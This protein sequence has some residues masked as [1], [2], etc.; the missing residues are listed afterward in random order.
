MEKKIIPFEA[1]ESEYT[2][3]EGYIAEIV[4][5]KVVVKKEESGVERIR[6]EIN[7]LYTDIDSCIAELLAARTNKDLGAEC[8]ALFKMEGL[9]VGALRDLSCIEDWFEKHK[10]PKLKNGYIYPKYRVGDTLHRHGWAEHTV[11]NIYCCDKPVYVCRNDEGLESHISLD[12][13]DKWVLV[14]KQKEPS[15]FELK[16]GKWYICHRAF[17]CRAD[18]LTVKEGERFQCEEDGVVKGFVMENPEKYFKECSAPTPIEQE[19]KP[20]IK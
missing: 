13:Q 15:H 18:H 8:K 19:Y 11:E 3:P 9:M 6:K 2:I 20:A 14:E 17:C 1:Q 16:A 5:R 12:E 7:T 4:D 10:E